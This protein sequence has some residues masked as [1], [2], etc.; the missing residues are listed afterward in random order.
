MADT[1]APGRDAGRAKSQARIIRSR[2]E[3]TRSPVPAPRVLNGYA[4][5]QYG[6]QSHEVIALAA[7]GQ[8]GMAA[9]GQIQL[10]A[11]TMGL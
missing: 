9:A 10:A 4:R 7:T 8:L 11:V 2:A 3:L 1:V 5:L 6:R